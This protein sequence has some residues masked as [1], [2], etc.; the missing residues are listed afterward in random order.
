MS[1]ALQSVSV[2][3]VGTAPDVLAVQIEW[4]GRW[5]CGCLGASSFLIG[6]IGR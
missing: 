2:Q 3:A 5:Y 1:G 6:T 4:D